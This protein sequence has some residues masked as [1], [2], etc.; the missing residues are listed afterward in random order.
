M[1]TDCNKYSKEFIKNAEG[2]I[3]DKYGKDYTTSKHLNQHML[4]KTKSNDK[5]TQEAHEAI[6]PTSVSVL[7]PNITQNITP[8][9]VRLYKLIRRN[10]LES[11]M[12]AAKYLSI[13]ATITAPQEHIYKYSTEQVVF[14]GW[15][16]V[17]GYEEENK[18][19]RYLQTLKNNSEL[20]YNK[21]I[22]K[23]TIKDLKSSLICKLE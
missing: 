21:I 8:K 7:E 13:T 16:I 11:C 19:F 18:D 5:N 22:C 3:K 6:R 9:E 2:Y 17:N 15:K 23:V 4:N 10:T 12:E 1:R 14:P 20:D